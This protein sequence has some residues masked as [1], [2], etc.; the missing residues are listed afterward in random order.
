MTITVQPG[1]PSAIDVCGGCTGGSCIRPSK[2]ISNFVPPSEL[3]PCVDTTSYPA[4]PSLW[5][6]PILLRLLDGGG[7]ATGA[8]LDAFDTRFVNVSLFSFTPDGSNLTTFYGSNAPSVIL[9]HGTRLLVRN[10]TV[11]LCPPFFDVSGRSVG[12]LNVTTGEVEYSVVW[13]DPSPAFCNQTSYAGPPGSSIQGA[14]IHYHVGLELSNPATGTYVFLFTSSCPPPSADGVDPGCP[15]AG[16]ALDGTPLGVYPVLQPAFLSITV[17]PGAP[18]FL[19]VDSVV[20]PLL[21]NG[22]VLVP[23][24]QLT[25]RDASANV[26]SQ[27]TGALVA[28]AGPPESLISIIGDTTSLVKGRAVFP[29]LALSGVRGKNLTITI[30]APS[31]LVSATSISSKTSTPTGRRSLG[32]A[33]PALQWLSVTIGIGVQPCSAVKPNSEPDQFGGCQCVPGFTEDGATGDSSGMAGEASWP[34]LFSQ[35][36]AVNGLCFGP[37][38]CYTPNGSITTGSGA[39]GTGTAWLEPLKPLK[40]CLPCANG[41][42]KW[43]HGPLPCEPCPINMDTSRVD[44]Q[45]GTLRT[46]MAGTMLL[47]YLAAYD[48]EQCQCIAP[49]EAVTA[50]PPAVALRGSGP[51]YF[52]QSNGTLSPCAPCPTGAACDGRTPPFLAALPGYWRARPQ[53]THFSACPSGADACAGGPD[54]ACVGGYVGP[55]CASCAPGFARPTANGAEPPLCRPCPVRY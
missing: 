22:L 51:S 32:D 36:I 25:V 21:E 42:T 12:V 26:C 48:P 23:P 54:S 39:D 6:R 13:S 43:K 40:A 27:V 44:G 46:S 18:A 55:L 30:S 29:T 31:V 53:S 28:E 50:P 49:P 38:P 9:P 37:A 19:S 7:A 3:G 34:N 24:L 45:L 10:G 16:I 41:F 17:V 20:P 35:V 4:V 2:G 5:I 47:S 1:Y 52:Q 11:G 15:S 33:A 8:A 14:G